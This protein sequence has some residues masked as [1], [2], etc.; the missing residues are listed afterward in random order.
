MNTAQG[1]RRLM[2]YGVFVIFT[3]YP[4]I[5]L[6]AEPTTIDLRFYNFFGCTIV[7]FRQRNYQ[8]NVYHSDSLLII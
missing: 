2:F 3:I 7:E 6:S 8:F 4:P 5:I 1:N